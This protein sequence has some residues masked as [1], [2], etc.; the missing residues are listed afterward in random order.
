MMRKIIIVS[1]LMTATMAFAKTEEPKAK[2]DLP[3]TEE[4]AL[5]IKKTI[6][7]KDLKQKE[8]VLIQIGPSASTLCFIMETVASQVSIPYIPDYGKCMDLLD[9]GF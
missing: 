2:T 8:V 6:Q 4:K 9:A 5:V 7:E 3:K 1:L